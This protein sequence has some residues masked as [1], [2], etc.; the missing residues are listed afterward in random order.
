MT[1]AEFESSFELVSLSKYNVAMFRRTLRLYWTVWLLFAA[2]VIVW[3]RLDTRPPFA[4]ESVYLNRALDWR[5]HFAHTPPVSD[6]W[7]SA[8]A[9]LAS[10]LLMPALTLHP[11]QATAAVFNLLYALIFLWAMMQI[12]LQFGRPGEDGLLAGFVVL[13]AQIV[14]F[15]GRR[16]FFD[17][18][19]LV[20][21]TA[22]MAFL[23]RTASF[24]DHDATLLWGWWCGLGVLIT[25]FY[26]LFF[27]LPCLM[28]LWQGPPLGARHPRPLRNFLRAAAIFFVMAFAW[29]GWRWPIALHDALKIASGSAAPPVNAGIATLLG[30]WFYWKA[31]W[32]QW[33][34]WTLLFLLIG[35][36]GLT[37]TWP[38]SAG[39]GLMIAWA[40]SA[41]LFFTPIHHKDARYTVPMMPA[42]AF[43]ALMGWLPVASTMK[44][45][46]WLWLGLT[47]LLV[48][49]SILFDRPREEDWA[50]DALGRF[51][52]THRDVDR[53]F[54]LASVVS[55]HPAL[56][57]A[58]LQWS[59]RS[60]RDKLWISHAGN[61]D[62]DFTEF[63]VVK[64]DG[65]GLSDPEL[66]SRWSN[67]TRNG[68][69]FTAL[70]PRV[71]AFHLPDGS[72]T[73]LYQWRADT[74]FQ[75][76]AA[77]VVTLER[78]LAKALTRY[79]QG[80]FQIILRGSPSE[81][82]RGMISSMMIEGKE[83]TIKQIPIAQANVRLSGVRLNLY[84]LYD[85]GR[86]GIMA[87]HTVAPELTINA[88]DLEKALLQH[89]IGLHEPHITFTQGRAEAE[90][91]YRGLPIR[92]TATLKL[93]QSP[94]RLVAT[95]KNFS[96]HGV[97]IPGWFLGMAYRQTL[98]LDP[99]PDFPATI[100]IQS[101]TLDGDVLHIAS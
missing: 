100:A 89:V 60:R 96:I 50:H 1:V 66:G 49:N 40:L 57:A 34:P 55:K 3:H 85:Q 27:V 10:F 6:P 67:W 5:D 35:F 61:P 28:L 91:L 73:Q 84:R 45:R 18:A 4:A 76:G 30:W 93:E 11:S 83:W 14:L 23:L 48:A 86:A 95:L 101:V 44:R 2:A 41:F 8:R 97:P 82:R 54:L 87:V 81:L 43:L 32:I 39:K 78:K 74:A 69:S 65:L 15:L 46:R 68:R 26:P 24:T 21:V 79:V 71:A 80:P 88:R 56:S 52:Q 7:T 25:P 98:P 53:P 12:A 63:I 33:G 36:A 72:Q 90:G 37:Q 42:L 13:G 77:D 47:A 29:Y 19:A 70:Y 38:R 59:F 62:L 58:P 16:A 17:F 20:W 99:T 64:S 92:V 75:I 51:M 31:F 9:P 94:R 22:G